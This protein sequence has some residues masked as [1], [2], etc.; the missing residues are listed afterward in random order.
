MWRTSRKRTDLTN[1]SSWE[2][3]SS[4]MG[5]F[6]GD[7]CAC[8]WPTENTKPH[9]QGICNRYPTEKIRYRFCE[10]QF[11]EIE[12]TQLRHFENELIYLNFLQNNRDRTLNFL[13]SYIIKVHVLITFSYFSEV[14]WSLVKRLSIFARIKVIKIFL[15]STFSYLKKNIYHI[16]I[17]N[18][19]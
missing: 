4:L 14:Q 6:T 5:K 1:W 3:T 9:T 18:I 8:T 13:M 15:W 16:L 17:N 2:L 12:R 11:S 19:I 7:G 10:V